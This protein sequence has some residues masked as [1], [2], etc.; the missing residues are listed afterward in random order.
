[1]EQETQK[2]NINTH[3]II[4]KIIISLIIL[5]TFLS[6]V[7]GLSTI[8]LTKLA[9]MT[10]NKAIC[11]LMPIMMERQFEKGE[12]IKNVVLLTDDISECKKLG[13]YC[14]DE[15]AKLMG[16]EKICDLLS[17]PGVGEFWAG[18]GWIYYIPNDSRNMC[19]REMAQFKKDLNICGFIDDKGATISG[20][21]KDCVSWVL[22]QRLDSCENIENNKELTD[23]CHEEMQKL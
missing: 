6:M 16:D 1:M 15:Y 5:L 7:P 18:S 4:S 19:Y 3:K 21:R 13:S 17:G 20:T 2:S 14:I 23:I 22:Y 8:P 9:C 10:K 11:N 12:C